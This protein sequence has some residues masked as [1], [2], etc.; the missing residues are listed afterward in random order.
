MLC[1]R[2]HATTRI[3]SAKLKKSHGRRTEISTLSSPDGM[4]TGVR[5]F[6][7]AVTITAHGQDARDTIGGRIPPPL[8]VADHTHRR[9]G[10]GTPSPERLANLDQNAVG[11]LPETNRRLILVEGCA[12]VDLSAEHLFAVEPD[13]D[14]VVAPNIQSGLPLVVGPDFGVSVRADVC[15]GLDQLLE[16][17]GSGSKGGLVGTLNSP[18]STSLPPRPAYAAARS[19][20]FSAG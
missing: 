1:S 3:L 19:V 9:P 8:A 18:P 2:T 14:G 13:C 17:D 5:P 6:R 20:F 7:C 16:V 15:A 11:A 4:V 10:N 12:A